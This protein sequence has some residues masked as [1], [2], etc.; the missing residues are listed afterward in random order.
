MAGAAGSAAADFAL[1]SEGALVLEFAS[2]AESVPSCWD[3][4]CDE[5]TASPAVLVVV[6]VVVAALS[7]AE[8]AFTFTAV[9]VLSVAVLDLAM[10]DET[11]LLRPLLKPVS[12][13][14]IA[15][16]ASEPLLAAASI[17]S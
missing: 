3:L 7:P 12:A 13:V 2:V 10:L 1:L 15:V 8:L 6:V 9:G 4:L 11:A 16:E 5:A 14:L 17:S